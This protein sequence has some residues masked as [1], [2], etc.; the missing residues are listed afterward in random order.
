MARTYY[1]LC[2]WTPGQTDDDPGCWSDEF[3]AYSRR[4]VEGEKDFAHDHQQRGWVKIIKHPEGSAA[5]M[6]ARD[7]LPKP[8]NG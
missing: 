6:A 7:A 2:V 4:E 8:K 1:T 3:G 5:M